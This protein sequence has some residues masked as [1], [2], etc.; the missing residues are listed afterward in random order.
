[1]NEYERKI[2]NT[3]FEHKR[4]QATLDIKALEENGVF[5]GYASVFDVVDSQADVMLR[6][7]FEQSIAA[8]AENVKLLWQHAQDE[9]IGVVEQLRE[10]VHGLYIKGRLLM[11]VARAREAYALLKA[12]VIKGLSIGYSPMRYR[13][14]RASGVR[15]LS[16]V[17]LWE[18][19][20]VTFPAN[21]AAQV[22]V[23]KSADSAG[24]LIRSLD[25][26]M[27]ALLD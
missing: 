6:G 10:D 7:A 25:H 12:G 2:S 27:H 9:P 5:A 15:Y 11:D 21:D 22:T 8:R 24:L 19:S 20:L 1:M 17:E 26:A 3:M 13:I 16:A 4:T 23:V 14:D 18:V